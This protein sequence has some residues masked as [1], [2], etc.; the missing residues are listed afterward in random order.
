[1]TPEERQKLIEAIK[2]AIGQEN[3]PLLGRLNALEQVVA[4]LNGS[5]PNLHRNGG[6]DPFASEAF[7]ARINQFKEGLPSTGRIHLAGVKLRDLLRMKALVNPDDNVSPL[8][9]FPTQTQRGQIVAP[10]MRPLTL[11]D[12][13]LS[14]PLTS[15]SF[16]FVQIQRTP[17]AAVQEQEG[18]LKAETVFTTSLE[19][20]KA[21]TIASW[22]DASRQVLADNPQLSTILRMILAYDVLEKLERLLVNGAGDA[23][24]VI[25]GLVPQSVLIDTDATIAPDIISEAL[26]T[27]NVAGYTVGVVAMHPFDFHRLRTLKAEGGDQQ[28]MVGSWASPAPQNVWNTPIVECSSLTEGEALLLDRSKAMVLDREE[29]QAMVSTETGDNF[30]RNLVTLLC[31]GRW[32]LA[33]LDTGG[34]GLVNLPI[35]SPA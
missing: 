33:V 1:M 4:G 20:A 6:P 11:L 8:T 19:T 15:A 26:A 12:F 13:L 3:G 10:A 28:Y 35:G 27:M 16:E 23:T 7:V 17:A 21:A 32:G 22:T 34:V 30:K 2:A 25:H 9:D 18:D 31:E 5:V 14:T 24:D 29:V